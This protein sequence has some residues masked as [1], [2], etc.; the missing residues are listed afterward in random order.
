MRT[1][2]VISSAILL[3]AATMLPTRTQADVTVEVPGALGSYVYGAGRGVTVDF[4]QPL[5]SVLGL[6]IHWRGS[7][8]AGLASCDGQAPGQ[9]YGVFHCEIEKDGIGRCLALSPMTDDEAFDRESSFVCPAGCDFLSDGVMSVGFFIGSD[10]MH[11][12]NSFEVLVP[13]QGTLDQVTITAVMV[14]PATSTA[15]GAIKSLYGH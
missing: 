2:I 8:A 5:T 4:G 6:R 13:P 1:P 9:W 3:I 10:S 11:C 12:W 14:V 15:W 7:I